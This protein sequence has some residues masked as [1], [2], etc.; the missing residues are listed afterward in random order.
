MNNIEFYDDVTNGYK[1]NTRNT[2]DYLK[3]SKTRDLRFLCK[4]IQ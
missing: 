3:K 1:T 2:F 4:S